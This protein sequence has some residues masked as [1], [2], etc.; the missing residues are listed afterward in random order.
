[1]S[2]A[3]LGIL[4]AEPFS[5]FCTEEVRAPQGSSAPRYGGLGW[6]SSDLPQSK[7]AK[8]ATLLGLA[9][10]GDQASHLPVPPQDG[11]HGNARDMGMA[12]KLPPLSESLSRLNKTF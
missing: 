1:M 5:S 2:M 8:G 9:S 12:I 7:L 10:A 3:G 11:R 4:P 6:S